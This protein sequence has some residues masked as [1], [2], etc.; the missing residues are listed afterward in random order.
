MQSIPLTGPNSNLT[1]RQIQQRFLRAVYTDIYPDPIPE[2]SSELIHL[3]L[4]VAGPP[5]QFSYQ[6]KFLLKD[7]EVISLRPITK[8]QVVKSGHPN[9]S[10]TG[11]TQRIQVDSQPQTATLSLQ[12]TTTKT[13][14]S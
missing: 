12:K 6:P 5:H 10:R 4:V 11:T 8:S 9:R 7:Q 14:I 2:G 3:D 1:E 13:D